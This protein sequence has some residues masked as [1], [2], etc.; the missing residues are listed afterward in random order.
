MQTSDSDS[1]FSSLSIVL[2]TLRE[3]SDFGAGEGWPK[4]CK[5]FLYVLNS[6]HVKKPIPIQ[7]ITYMFH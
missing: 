2:S 1:S 5:L 3:I 6:R 4:L 7:H